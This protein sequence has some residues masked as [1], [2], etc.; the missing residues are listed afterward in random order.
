MTYCLA[1]AVDE[2]LVFASDSRTHAGV[3]QVS[4]YSKMFAYARPGERNLVVLSAGNL[5][6]TQ[7][8][9]RRLNRD[10]QSGAEPSLATAATL[11][12]A[13]EYL[14]EVSVELQRRTVEQSG[15]QTGLAVEATF[16]IG[17]QIQGQAPGIYMVYPQGNFITAS[18]LHP[19]LQI[20]ETKYGKPILDRIVSERLEL[21][22]AATCALISIDSTMRSNLS[23]GPPVELLTYRRDSL[24]PGH[25]RAFQPDDPYFAG[26]RE[27]WRDGLQQLFDQLP[28]PPLDPADSTTC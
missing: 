5:A 4:T 22:R 15:Q 17:G 28:A 23:V 14:G 21:D 18:P 19:F 7:A 13:A 26:L 9:V 16:L 6:T 20:G 25:Y 27:A 8:V 1:I 3:D 10:W 12:D 11:E 2:G 24:E